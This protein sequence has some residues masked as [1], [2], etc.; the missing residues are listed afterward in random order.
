MNIKIHTFQMQ[1]EKINKEYDM[2][3]TYK[4]YPELYKYI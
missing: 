4:I 2:F 1:Q 3:R